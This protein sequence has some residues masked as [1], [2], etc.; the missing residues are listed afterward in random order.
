MAEDKK[1]Q[2]GPGAP[3]RQ[4]GAQ[5]VA[6]QTGPPNIIIGPQ[7]GQPMPAAY[8]ATTTPAPVAPS[9]TPAPLSSPPV[10]PYI[11]AQASY[12]PAPI[13]PTSTPIP[14]SAQNTVVTP[15]TTSYLPPSVDP[16]LG[17]TLAGRYVISKKLGEGGMG[18]V[19]LA[20]HNLLDKQV[21]LKILHNEFARKPDL[22]ER[23]MQEAKSASRIRHE[24]VIDISDF[25]MTND[26][27]VFFAMELL[28]GHDLHE[29]IARARLAGQLL[30]WARS[31][32]IFLQIC[33]ALIAA[34]GH[35][36]V[37]RD[38]KPENIYLIDFLGEGDFVKLLDFGIAKLTEVTDDGRKL[39]RTGML[40][41]TPE[42]MS[43]EQARGEPVDHRVDVY[44]MGCI[45]F[46][47][48]TGRVPFEADNFMGVLS[49]HLTEPPPSI[50][51]DVFDRIGAPRELA[52]VIDKALAKDRDQRWQ[53]IAE[54][55]NAV[56]MVSGDAPMTAQMPAARVAESVNAPASTITARPRTQWTGNLSV[57]Q[58]PANE[59]PH[60]APKSKLPL[61]IGA[62]VVLGGGG[63]AAF[64]AT[65]GGHTEP[66]VT[67]GSASGS[68]IA[69]APADAMVV[70]AAKPDAA[71][72]AP[73][74]PLPE[75][76]VIHLDSKPH[77]AEIFEL[78][79]N[80]REVLLDKTPLT[81][82]L[83][84]SEVA[85]Q[86]SIRLKGYSNALIELTPNA[87]KIEDTETLEKGAGTA[88]VA[89]KVVGITTPGP[90]SG[91]GSGSSGVILHPVPE[92]HIDA[93][94]VEVAAKPD[95]AP[96]IENHP[97]PP[98][99]AAAAKPPEDCEM[100]CLKQMPGHP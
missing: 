71:P 3:S 45:L 31:K 95:A 77:G 17:Q 78:K 21:A 66:L 60:A 14:A 51:V 7:T 86:F 36:I 72:L 44:A 48:I 64:F 26:G 28:K 35:G 62:L 81:F 42:Y 50:P 65:R 88:T 12:T 47:L 97:P 30:P 29:E 94:V 99:D 75:W 73:P 92:L 90:G 34:H 11:P 83:K 9:Y 5:P 82:K 63:A 25:G 37:H 1:T 85:R 80:G 23:F 22:V 58:V 20:T 13:E 91:A 43:P 24:N 59:V 27:L 69:G 55:A 41:G 98:I 79:D 8:P 74:A 100:P 57:P 16:L 96:V 67:P 39:T 6:P 46:Q 68:V 76:S 89:K 54:L 4:T 18:A 87:E 19:Y 10:P 49:L 61:V 32:R 84:G 53:T 15:G 56:R 52:G 38:L 33:A 2:F 70:A 93:G 40:F